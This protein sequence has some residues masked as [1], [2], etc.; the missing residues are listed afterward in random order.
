MRESENVRGIGR[1]GKKDESSG[2]RGLCATSLGNQIVTYY[3][4]FGIM[5]II[6]KITF[7]SYLSLYTHPFIFSSLSS[8]TPSFISYRGL[9]GINVFMTSSFEESRGSKGKG[10]QS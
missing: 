9:N 8:I 1:G 10:K 7:S 4:I 5:K 3:T 6:P 2:F